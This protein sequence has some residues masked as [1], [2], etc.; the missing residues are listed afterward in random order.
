[1]ALFLRL[2]ANTDGAVRQIGL[3]IIK[4]ITEENISV[5]NTVSDADALLQFREKIRI[6]YAKMFFYMFCC[7]I[8][9][10]FGEILAFIISIGVVFML[11]RLLFLYHDRSEEHTSELQSQSNL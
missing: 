11:S 8:F 1:M 9:G 10:C 2:F 7:G 4:E 5:D 3:G 6:N